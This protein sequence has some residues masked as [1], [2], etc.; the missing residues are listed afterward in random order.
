MFHN[1]FVSKEIKDN[2]IFTELMELVTIPKEWYDTLIQA[3]CHRCNELRLDNK[4]MKEY[5]DF[6][7]SRKIEEDLK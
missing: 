6:L 5:I 7:N 3:Y 1:T 4:N 2:P